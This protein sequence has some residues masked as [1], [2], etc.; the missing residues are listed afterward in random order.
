M[1]TLGPHGPSALVYISKYISNYYN[2]IVH[3]HAQINLY[4]NCNSNGRSN[5]CV[6]L[7]L[8]CASLATKTIK[9]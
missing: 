8:L 2:F 9:E 4:S 7:H 3:I 5:K 1:T 6:D